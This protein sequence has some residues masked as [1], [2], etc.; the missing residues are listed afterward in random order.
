MSKRLSDEQLALIVATHTAR[1]EP[2]DDAIVE[3]PCPLVLA[4]RELIELRRPRQPASATE[5]EDLAAEMAT[6]ARAGQ[7]GQDDILERLRFVLELGR[8]FPDIFGEQ[9]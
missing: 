2:C 9:P 5:L 1:H 7:L 3:E 8:R 6:L 4:A